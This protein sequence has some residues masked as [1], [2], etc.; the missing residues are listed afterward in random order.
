MRTE[1]IKL[2]KSALLALKGYFTC[3]LSA[4]VVDQ[5]DSRQMQAAWFLHQACCFELAQADNQVLP[6]R[7][8]ARIEQIAA[9]LAAALSSTPMLVGEIGS[10]TKQL[11]DLIAD[12]GSSS[13][14]YRNPVDPA[15]QK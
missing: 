14:T 12:P 15:E 13:G 3:S 9:Q 6:P 8:H 7:F 11:Y 10:A 5:L 1:L 2:R 4:D